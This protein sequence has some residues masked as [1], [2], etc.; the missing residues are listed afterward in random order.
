MFFGLGWFG[1]GW[2]GSTVDLSIH[3]VFFI[4]PKGRFIYL[5]SLIKM[6]G[7]IYKKINISVYRIQVGSVSVNVTPIL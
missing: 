5:F 7:F 1:L 2:V 3:L 6:R 4:L